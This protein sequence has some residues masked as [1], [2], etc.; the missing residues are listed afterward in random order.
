MKTPALLMM[1]TTFAM[2]TFFTVYYF[3]KVI[4][5]SK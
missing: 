3:V 1:V 4:K 2:V 5:K